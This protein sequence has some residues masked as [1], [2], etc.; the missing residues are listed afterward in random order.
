MTENFAQFVAL[1][2]TQTGLRVRTRR[3]DNDGEYIS[4]KKF[5]FCANHGI[6]QRF[7]PPYTPQ[8]HGVAEKMSRTLVESA[9]CIRK[10]AGLTKS[11]WDET[12]M[13]ATFLRVRCPTRSTSHNKSPYQVWMKKVLLLAAYV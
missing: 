10:H 4:S 5:K 11:Y 6:M 12:V 8:L 7:T 2:E 1:A 3:S 9:R 13:T